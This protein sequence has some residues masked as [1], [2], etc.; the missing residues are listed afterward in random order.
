MAFKNKQPVGISDEAKTI[1][2]DKQNKKLIVD[3]LKTEQRKY[4]EQGVCPKCASENITKFTPGIWAFIF[5]GNHIN[6]ADIESWSGRIKIEGLITF[7][8]IVI[9]AMACSIGL[10]IINVLSM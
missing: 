9:W 8:S 4:M 5:S 2:L 10:A 6:Y 3:K 1:L 7:I